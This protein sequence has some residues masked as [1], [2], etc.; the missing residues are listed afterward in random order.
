MNHL[1]FALSLQAETYNITEVQVG[2][3]GLESILVW[4][5]REPGELSCAAENDKGYDAGVLPVF[6][7]DVPRGFFME[8]I[9]ENIVEGDN[10]TLICGVT[11]YKYRG[12]RWWFVAEAGSNPLLLNESQSEPTKN[13]SYWS[14]V[15]IKNL[16]L[17]HS[18]N[19][20]CT[21]TEKFSLINKEE[22]ISLSVLSKYYS[23]FM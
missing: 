20:T 21:A 4:N 18:G 19:Y 17:T 6:V 23:L 9:P 12:N 14:R 5:M 3:Y 15:E 22:S 13:Y 1:L 11:S 16:S 10:L 2:E 8:K 7:T